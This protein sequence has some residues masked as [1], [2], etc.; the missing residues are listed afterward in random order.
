MGRIPRD[1]VRELDERLG[2]GSAAAL[3]AATDQ[4][5]NALGIVRRCIYATWLEENYEA[6]PEL[7]RFS[8]VDHEGVRVQFRELDEKYPFATRQRVRECVFAKYPDRWVTPLQTGQLGILNGELSKRRKQMPVRRLIARIPN[9]LQTL[10]PCFLMSPL[11]VSQYLPSG[12][13]ASDHL[14]FD[15]VIFDEASQVWPEDAIPAIERGR[16]VIVVGDRMQLPPTNFFRKG[17]G[18]DDRTTMMM[19]MEMPSKAARVFSTRWWEKL[20]SDTS[21]CTTEAVQRVS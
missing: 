20:A 9:L 17:L 14:E 13:L 11:A 7:R 19:T 1:A 18:D 8:R 15:A 5:E 21:T 2:L 10:K 4:A 3:R 16:Q 12:P 6:E